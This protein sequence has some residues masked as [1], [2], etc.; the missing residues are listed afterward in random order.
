MGRRQF[1]IM[2]PIFS[3]L[4]LAITLFIDIGCHTDSTNSTVTKNDTTEVFKTLLDSAFYRKRLPDLSSLK[5]NNPFGDTIIFK[6]NSILIGHLPLGFKF[7]MLT[8]DDI[9]T[10]ATQYYNDTTYFCNFLEL[11]SFKMVDTTY[12]VNLQNRCVVPLFDKNG[13]RRFDKAFYKNHAA[14]KCMFGFMCGGG[15]SMTFTRQADTLHAKIN[16]FWPD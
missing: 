8:Q 6:F 12:E 13:K 11:N 2:L 9:C 3:I 15:L 7:K 5:R 14:V 16:G 4:V 10:L 1:Q